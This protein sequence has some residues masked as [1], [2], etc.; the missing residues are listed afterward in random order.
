MPDG[1]MT[2]A[3]RMPVISG[4]ATLICKQ[5]GSRTQ[6]FLIVSNEPLTIFAEPLHAL[7]YPFLISRRGIGGGIGRLTIWP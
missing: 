7:C 4:A 6:H 3:D 5:F 2:E 1:F